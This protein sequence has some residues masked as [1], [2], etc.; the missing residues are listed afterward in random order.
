MREIHFLC[1]CVWGGGGVQGRYFVGGVRGRFNFT[2]LEVVG[3][4]VSVL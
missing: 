1:V 3:L 2:F 4:A